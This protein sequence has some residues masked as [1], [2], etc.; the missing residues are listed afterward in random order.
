MRTHAQDIHRTLAAL[1]LVA[2]LAAPARAA[3]STTTKSAAKSAHA[4]AAMVMPW[5]EDDYGKA[6][7]EAKARKVPIFVESWA[8]W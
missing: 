2:L 6:I 3:T 8:P 7:A 4:S 1:S 5:V